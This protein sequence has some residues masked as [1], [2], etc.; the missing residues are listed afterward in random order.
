MGKR[1]LGRRP[2]GP[3]GAAGGGTAARRGRM[4]GEVG[5]EELGGRGKKAA[6]GGARSGRRRRGRS[7][8]GGDL[9]AA[10]RRRVDGGE[11]RVDGEEGDEETIAEI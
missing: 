10:R 8:L 7:R 11:G 6:V 1:R 4:A 3:S 9:R 5:R 2:L